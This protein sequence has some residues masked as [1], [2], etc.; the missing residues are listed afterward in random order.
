MVD[1]NLN[2]TGK[3]KLF[4]AAKYKSTQESVNNNL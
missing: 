2:W 1:R 4:I 3:I